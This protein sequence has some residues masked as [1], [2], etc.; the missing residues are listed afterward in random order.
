MYDAHFW[1]IFFGLPLL[2]LL[3]TAFVFRPSAGPGYR[4]AKQ[5]IFA[6]DRRLRP[7]EMPD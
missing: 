1:V 7:P 5:V 4:A 2:F 3:I 6:D